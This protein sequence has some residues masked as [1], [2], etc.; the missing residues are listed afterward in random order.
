MKTIKMAAPILAAVAA[1][2][3]AAPAD[4]QQ[5]APSVCA[6]VVDTSGSGVD[7]PENR[8]WL[9]STLSGVAD[10]HQAAAPEVA[11]ILFTYDDAVHRLGVVGDGDAGPADLVA[12]AMQPSRWTNPLPAFEEMAGLDDLACVYHITDGTFDLAPELRPDEPAYRASVMGVASALGSRGAPVVTIAKYDDNGGLW[13]SVAD[14]SGGLYLITYGIG[15][16]EGQLSGV[17]RDLSSTPT[18]A[19]TA[20]LTPVPRPDTRVSNATRSA[21]E[22]SAPPWVLIGVAAGAALLICLVGW[23]AV[24]PKPRP[25]SGVLE[26]HSLEDDDAA[27]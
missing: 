18:P 12:A 10:V 7:L 3:V 2:A 1:L 20:E 25:L 19:P 22:P 24:R 17:L 11:L 26:I 21:T 6:I 23:Q 14:A 5:T 15:D 8:T 16:V 4:G 9:L 27:H 13:Q